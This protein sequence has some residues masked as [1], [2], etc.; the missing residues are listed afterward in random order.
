[1]R[2]MKARIGASLPVGNEEAGVVVAAGSDPTA[3][4]LLGNTVGMIGGASA[5]LV[6]CASLPR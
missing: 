5:N 1:M 4:A 3:Q 6:S 2:A